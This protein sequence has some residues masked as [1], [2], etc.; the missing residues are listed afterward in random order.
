MIGYALTGSFC[1]VQ[2]SLAVLQEL[3][4]YNDVLPI[5]SATVASTDTRFGKAADTLKRLEDI[6]GKKPITTVKEAE[7]L[8]PALPLDTLVICPCTGNTL[9]KLAN[10]ITDTAVTMAAKAHLRN[11]RPLIIAIATNDGLSQSLK[12][13]AVMLN[14]KNV[15]FVPF[16][17]DD[18]ESK[19]SS[20]VADF[21]LVSKTVEKAR[22]GIQ[23][24]P[25]LLR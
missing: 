3:I 2:R 10:G 8:G 22:E 16:G 12:N 14:R 20:L 11:G 4:L 7:P 18:P 1:T 6:C 17:Q 9:A 23:L 25:V 5:A 19:P 21:S 24:Q 13:L 15:Y